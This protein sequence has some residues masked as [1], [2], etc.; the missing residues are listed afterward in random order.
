MRRNAD[1]GDKL[2]AGRSGSTFKKREK[3]MARVNKQREKLA[4]R[5]ERKGTTIDEQFALAV[6]EAEAG[7]PAYTGEDGD[8]IS[9]T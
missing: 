2:M 5:L 7:P 8:H 6:K 4:K 1:Q 9:D 3:E